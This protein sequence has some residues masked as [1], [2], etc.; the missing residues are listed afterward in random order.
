MSKRARA[1]ADLLVDDP[2][3]DVG[4]TGDGHTTLRH[5]ASGFAIA[6]GDSEETTA[7]ENRAALHPTSIFMVGFK[8]WLRLSWWERRTL[9]R[10]LLRRCDLI[11]RAGVHRCLA[12]RGKLVH[13]QSVATDAAR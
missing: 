13:L 3:W 6:F 4:Q 9:R 12:K 5:D 11:A 7:W 2:W 1:V 8:H 10:A